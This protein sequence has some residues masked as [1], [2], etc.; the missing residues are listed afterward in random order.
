[1][2]FNFI[3]Y[4]IFFD[5]KSREPKTLEIHKEIADGNK[6]VQKS[7]IHRGRIIICTP[8]GDLCFMS[9]F[10]LLHQMPLTFFVRLF[11]HRQK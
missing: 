8:F 6:S 4:L 10:L 5:K 3:F 9:T 11:C 1:M 7:I 2:F